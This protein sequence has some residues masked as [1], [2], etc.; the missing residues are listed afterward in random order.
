MILPLNIQEIFDPI[1][2]EVF[3]DTKTIKLDQEA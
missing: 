3:K 1:I 2:E